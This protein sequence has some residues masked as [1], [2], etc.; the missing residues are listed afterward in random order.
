MKLSVKNKKKLTLHNRYQMI[1]RE[2][3][4]KNNTLK[5][6]FRKAKFEKMSVSPYA[7]FRGS[8]HLYWADFYNDWRFSLYGGKEETLTWINGDA[9]IYNYGAY[10]NHE[11]EAIFGMDDF[12]DSIVADYQY[13]LWRMAISIVL[14]CRNNA[15]FDEHVQLAALKAF[16]D[17]Y[18]EEITSYEA[19]DIHKEVQITS[20][21]ANGILKD[22]LNKVE[23]KKSRKKMLG[24]WTIYSGGERR[25][26]CE[27]RKLE[28]LSEYEYEALAGVM[29][30]YK[31]TLSHDFGDKG[32][33]YFYVKDIARRLWSGTGSLGLDRFYVLLEG[34]RSTDDDDIILDVKALDKPPIY[35][36]MSQIEQRAY[37]EVFRHEGERYVEAFTALTEHPDKYLGWLRYNDQ[38]FSVREKSPFKADFPSEKIKK[39][40]DLY[41]MAHTWGKLLATRH[42]R[43]SHRLNNDP[44]AFPKMMQEMTGGREERFTNLV[45]ELSFQYADCVNQDW[46]SFLEVEEV[47]EVNQE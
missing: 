7:F 12:D 34:D 3:I 37:G 8:N 22:F 1:T 20:K 33:G 21:T 27:N 19:D 17:A 29:D 43:A 24:K 44:Y 36:H 40:E 39:E 10:A 9:H 5:P 11:G 4:D 38:I 46:K 35:A 25:F 31:E 26:N 45:A 42:E 13:D 28:R 6:V 15:V 47:L 2:L 41:F 32:E 14:D 30:D 23:S 16:I 18:L